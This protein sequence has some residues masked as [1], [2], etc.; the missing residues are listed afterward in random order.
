MPKSTAPFAL[1]DSGLLLP[2]NIFNTQKSDYVHEN[3]PSLFLGQEPG[4]FDTVNK[5]HPEIW[6]IYKNMRSL[7]WDENEFGFEVCNAEFKT[8]PKSIADCMTR[9]LAWQWEADSVAART[10]LPIMAPFISAPELQAAW[11]RITDNEVLHAS[12]Y[13]EIV[14]LSFDDPSVVLDEVLRVKEAMQRLSVVAKIMENAYVVSHQYALGLLDKNKKE[15]FI[16][17]YDAAFMFTV[18]MLILERIQ[19]MASFAVTFAIGELGLF[20]PIAKAVQKICQDEYEIHQNLDKAVLRNEM[21]LDVGKQAYARN[22]HVIF[23]A[24]AEARTCEL[25]WNRYVL[26]DEP[27]PGLTV[28]NLDAWVDHNTADV[29]AFFGE[30]PKDFTAPSKIPLSYMPRWMNI[31]KTQASPQE[32]QNGQYK[33]NVVRDDAQGKIFPMT[34]AGNGTFQRRDEVTGELSD[35]IQISN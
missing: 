3:K 22:K 35:P 15:D 9:T 2:T 28:K 7:D 29:Y 21:R 10:I 1:A 23:A 19:F 4:L 14:R 12:T 31:S 18:A 20:M 27:L 16:K 6:E 13:S 26:A 33:V 34:L 11:G 32:Q 25:T 8:Q 30:K 24:V 17:I 5:V